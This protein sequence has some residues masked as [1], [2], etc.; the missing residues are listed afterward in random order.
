MLLDAARGL[1]EAITSETQAAYGAR[2]AALESTL[3]RGR[4]DQPS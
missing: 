1:R 3:D 4:E 2:F